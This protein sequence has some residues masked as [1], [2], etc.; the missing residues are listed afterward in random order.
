MANT[1]TRKRKEQRWRQSE[2][3]CALLW[4]ERQS[5]ETLD[6]LAGADH[7]KL[8]ADDQSLL[9]YVYWLINHNYITKAK[10]IVNAHACSNS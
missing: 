8:K 2:R 9:S 7:P 10:E 6:A 3:S 4:L 5:D 1:Q